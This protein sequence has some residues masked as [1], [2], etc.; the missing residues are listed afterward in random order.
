MIAHADVA[1]VLRQSGVPGAAIA[2]VRDGTLS[3]AFGAGTRACRGGPA[4]DAHTRFAI[5][6][7]TK[8]FVAVAALQAA[9][10]GR[11]RLDA[12]VDDYLRGASTL[13]DVTVRDLLQQRS[14]IG[15]Y[16]TPSF[17]L[18]HALALVPPSAHGIERA[19][20]TT[21]PHF[22]PG[23]QFEYS[24]ANYYLL[25]AALERIYDAP[26]ER[27]VARS[28]I[29]PLQ[30]HDTYFGVPNGPDAAEACATL[31]WGVAA[32]VQ[33]PFD[34]TWAAGGMT[35]SAYDVA[36]FEGALLRGELLH[37]DMQ[38]ILFSPGGG[39]ITP[40]GDYAASWFVYSA[41]TQT[42]VW[43]DG[44]VLGFKSAVAAIPAQRDAVIVLGNADYLHA[45]P[46]AFT[47]AQDR[48]GLAGGAPETT[49]DPNQP[50]LAY[51]IA[52]LAALVAAAADFMRRRPLRA[53]ALGLL[54]YIGVAAVWWAPVAIAMICWLAALLALAKGPRRKR[55][56]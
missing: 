15:D 50:H 10:Q 51:P 37:A 44:T 46:L 26:V 52:V 35:S 25:A 41:G 39:T 13:H 40:A 29:G 22:T 18:T 56:A 32:T 21:S 31:P 27:I 20:E 36:R 48:F 34:Y 42:A 43:H 8:Q 3:E 23:T 38:R 28:T 16:N 14:G 1:Q 9:Q 2:V 7:L 17:V 12:P 47:L 33:F 54:T 53:L 55:R 24:N 11:L 5:A 19:L 45:A 6:S 30:L 49:L 4:P